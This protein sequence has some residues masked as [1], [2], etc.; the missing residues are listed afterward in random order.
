MKYID[1]FLNSYG[2]RVF[3]LYVLIL[4]ILIYLGINAIALGSQLTR[5][6][7]I[8]T[9]YSLAS[10][11]NVENTLVGRVI[12]GYLLYN[13]VPNGF[14]R[15]LGYAL[16]F[17]H[18][19]LALFCLLLFTCGEVNAA[20]KNARRHVLIV[21]IVQLILTLAILVGCMIITQSTTTALA[22]EKVHLLGMGYLVVQTLVLITNVIVPFVLLSRYSG[23]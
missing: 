8:D 20:N 2:K 1:R 3:V 23:N 17:W 16:S 4:V 22:I 6:T 10:F 14:A 9:F 7:N 19:L 13:N 21:L 5:V 15:M 12:V 11:T 18:L